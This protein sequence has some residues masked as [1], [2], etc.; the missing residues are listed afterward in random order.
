M[1]IEQIICVVDRNNPL[2][3]TIIARAIKGPMMGFH[4]A[5]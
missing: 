2:L 4:R 3:S 5:L 1:I